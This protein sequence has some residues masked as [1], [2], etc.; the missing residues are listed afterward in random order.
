MTTQTP[1]ANDN[2][3][4]PQVAITPLA[5]IQ[6]EDVGRGAVVFDT[7]LRQTSASFVTLERLKGV[8]GNV[9]VAGNSIALVDALGDIVILA[10]NKVPDPV[11]C[12]TFAINLIGLV[13]APASG[14][15][16]RMAL[17]PMLFIVRQEGKQVLGDALIELMAGHLN[18]DIVGS[19]DDFVSQTAGHLK[20]ALSDAAT[21]GEQLILDIATG[22]AALAA[23]TGPAPATP[24]AAGGNL[25]V[26]DPQ[27]SIDNYLAGAF[28]A[29]KSAGKGMTSA[30]LSPALSAAAKAQLLAHIAQLRTLAPLVRGAILKLGDAGSPGSIEALRLTLASSVA[31]WRKRNPQVVVA[32]V[33]AGS[34]SK[35]RHQVAEGKVETQKEQAPAL[36]AANQCKNGAPTGTCNSIDFALGSET[37]QHT[38]FSL[39]GPFPVSWTRT[40]HSRLAA[41]DGGSLGAR[42]I[43]AFTTCIDVRDDGLLLHDIDGRSHAYPLLK[44][45]KTHY[46]PVEYRGLTRTTDSQL[47][48]SRGQ[49]RRETYERVGER[50]YLV[51]I[52]MRNGVGAT[53]HYEHFHE[54]RP[55]LSDINTYQDDDPTKVHL[56]LGT[57]LDEHGH[58]QGL[59][60]VVDGKPLRQLCAYHYDDH[61]DLIAAQDEHG[62]AWQY[63]Y[64]HHLITRYT[65]R[66][67]RGQH[68]EWDGSGPH[69][70]A[71]REWADD[72][73][74]E[75]RLAWDTHIRLTTVTDAHGGQTR[76]Y[77]DAEGYTYRI[78]HA[79]GRSEWLFRDTR[80][81]VIR[82]LH[83]DGGQD[84]YVYDERSNR[85]QH[86]RADHSVVHYAYDDQDQLIKL[87][88]AEGGLWRRDY[89]AVGNLVETVDPLGNKT[90]FAYTSTGQLKAIKDANGN[91][92]KLAY[93]AAG[94]LLEYTDCSGKS[95]QWAY[96]EFGRLVQ[97]TNAMGEQVQYAYKAGQLAKVTH[98]DQ[99][100]ERFERDAEGRL[101]AHVDALDRC[102]TWSYTPAGL[103]SERVDAT[104]HTLR[105][106]WDKLGRLVGLD[107]QNESRATFSYDVVGRL[108]AETGFDGLVK[109]YHYDPLT[110]RLAHTQVGQRRI[111]MR[112]DRMGRLIERTASL[113][114]QVESEHYAYNGNGQLL[115]ARNAAS[116]LQW[117]HDEAG[118]MVREHQHYLAIGTPMVAV[119]Q[120]EY[121][122]LNRRV[123]TLRP[124]GHKVSWLTYGSGH[125]LGMMLDHHEMLAFERDDLHRE[126]VRHQ[127]NKLMHKQQWSMRGRPLEQ[128]IGG[129]DGETTLL[130]RGYEY[131]TVGQL[132]GIHDTRRGQLTYQ[133][134]PLGRLLQAN[135]RLGVETFSFDPAGNLVDE[136]LQ[137]NRP[138]EENARNGK[139]MDNRL[140]QFD[141][142]HFKYDERGNLIH[143]LRE[144]KHA[145]LAWDLFDRLAHY[146]D[147]RLKVEYSYDALGRRLH[148]HSV[149]HYWDKPDAGTGWN[150]MQRAKRQRELKCGFTL[151]G[152]DGNALAWESSPARDDGDTG[153]T[154]H[155]LYLPGSFVPVAQAVRNGPVRLHKRPD[156]SGREYD[157]EQDPLWQTDVKPQAFDSIFWYQCDHLGT[158]MELTDEEGHV[159]WAAHYKAW[160]DLAEL[161]GSSVAMSNARNP[162]RFQGQYQDQETG[163]HYNRF[164]Y[165]DPKSARY[166]SKD[167]IGFMGG[168]NAYTYTGGSPVTATDPMGLKSWEWNGT[169]DTSLCTYYD[170][171]ACQTK[172]ELSRYYGSAAEICRGE[173]LIVN[174]AV[175][176]G[177]ITAWLKGS[178]VSEAEYY[179]RIRKSLIES[180][181]EKVSVHGVDGVTGDMI[182]AYHDKAFDEAGLG[183]GFYGGNNWPQA[184]RPNPVPYDPTNGWSYD[185]RN[186]LFKADPEQ[187]VGCASK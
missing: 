144:G 39:P 105:C 147:D 107:N 145:H 30:N 166:V 63:Q 5:E 57:L 183:K 48:L 152:W 151:F 143:R 55:V 42:W 180:D 157:F 56:Q 101:L 142:T 26:H 84:R 67:G 78:Q 62:A 119:W 118:N 38:D 127:G 109:Q 159:V 135:S 149:A 4:A 36:Q 19:L 156:W 77:Y 116:L 87:L 94:Q 177:V 114:E 165:Y 11:A 90:E 41:L 132:A 155:Y 66:T 170:S 186:W 3:R 83:A 59:W 70:R 126:I 53:L 115:Q 167:P 40:Y 74:F 52:R 75:T 133:Y 21:L 128:V 99:T 125:L 46:D 138:L 97:A 82:H 68:L 121:D 148:K 44:V 181:R 120:H 112:F 54:G 47:I 179:D 6:V 43:T 140:R 131:D 49:E 162:I 20:A 174:S 104:E 187:S 171:R 150:Q 10:G 124:D 22:L 32:N 24:A 60:Q 23:S 123:A 141:G 14:A 28:N 80:K 1:A 64:Q 9:A 161:P 158:P 110:G 163:L 73:S 184:V 31:Q 93:N 50:F 146:N 172:G 65:D 122:V 69:A 117:F 45:G 86:I 168:A 139:L 37:L 85:L 106:H 12:A 95:S 136:A 27:A 103:P 98:P 160:G 25:L 130:K 178:E 102:T 169:G 182:D 15:A 29:Y 61:G 58:I 2:L 88:D 113:G 13:R 96:D 34:T 111:T 76:H 129:A 134:D 35:A 33:K 173:N 176:A 72:G 8:A 100:E 71:I 51:H 17:R 81:N 79:D 108:L 175:S 18:A 7:W 154:V 91:E 89:D 16:A 153:S 185:P 137:L 164:R 92:K